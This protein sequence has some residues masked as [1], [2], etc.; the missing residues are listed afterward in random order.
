MIKAVATTRYGMRVCKNLNWTADIQV[1]SELAWSIGKSRI[2]LRLTPRDT[3]P[4][5]DDHEIRP[6]KTSSDVR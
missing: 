4:R 2:D 6:T 1:W 3:P 5:R